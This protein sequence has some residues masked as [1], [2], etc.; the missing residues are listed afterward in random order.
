MPNPVNDFF[1]IIF[2][3]NYTG[4]LEI[5]I[6]NTKGQEISNVNGFKARQEYAQSFSYQFISGM[7][8][9]EVSAGKESLT[10]K[11]LIGQ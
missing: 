5:K 11:I 8:F 4:N 2:N 6:F 10:Q 3:S 7:Y 9:L 1:R